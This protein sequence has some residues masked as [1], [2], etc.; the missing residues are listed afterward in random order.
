VRPTRRHDPRGTVVT[1]AYGPTGE[2]TELTVAGQGTIYYSYGPTGNMDSVLH[3]CLPAVWRGK[4][5]KGT[6]YEFDGA[7]KVRLPSVQWLLIGSGVT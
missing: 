1:Y 5:D 6:Y 2:R 4:M 3:A 7:R